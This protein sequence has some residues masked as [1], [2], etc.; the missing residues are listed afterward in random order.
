[1]T[2]INDDDGGGDDGDAAFRNITLGTED[3]SPE[4]NQIF[5][6]TQDEYNKI[7]DQI[8]FLTQDANYRG[9]NLLR[10]EN[11]E[12]IFNETRTSSLITEGIDATVQGLGLEREDFTSVEAVQRKIDQVQAAREELRDYSRTL[13]NDF[14]IIQNR[15]DF[16]R[17]S[18]NTLSSGSDDLVL[19]D[20]NEAGAK[21]LALQTRQAIQ[22]SVLTAIPPSILNLLT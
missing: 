12:T 4:A 19:L 6:D 17:T 13:T 9:T 15:L 8:D 11:L 18:I 10:N 22:T 16:T 5:Q 1:M 3:Y 7:L 2:F 21:L 20:Q 14:G